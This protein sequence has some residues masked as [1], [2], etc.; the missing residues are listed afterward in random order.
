MTS[1][2]AD[3]PCGS[4]T[5]YDACCGRLHRGAAQAA[6]PEELMRSRYAAYAVGETDYVWRTWHPRTR[7]DSVAQDPD[8]RWT[9]LDIVATGPDWVEFVARY[10]TPSGPGELREHSRFARRAGRWFYLDGDVG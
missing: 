7:P 2:R 3:C 9:G 6:T 8:L 1:L 10:E 5:A 4:G